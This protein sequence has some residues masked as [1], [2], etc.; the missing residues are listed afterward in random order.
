MSGADV[1]I[2]YVNAVT[3]FSATTNVLVAV[4][5]GGMA[6]RDFNVSSGPAMRITSLSK[7]ATIQNLISVHRFAVSLPRRNETMF[8]AVNGA[9]L[10]E[11]SVLSITGDGIIMGPTTFLPNRVGGGTI[12]SLVASVMVTDA[13]TPGLRS[14]VVRH[15]NDVAYA[16]GYVEIPAAVTDYNFDGLDDYFQRR[17]WSPWTQAAAGPVADPDEDHFSNAFEARMET[18][19]INAQSFRLPISGVTRDGDTTRVTVQTDVGKRYQLFERMAF[20]GGTWAA[21]GRALTATGMELTF[22]DV[23][24]LEASFYRVALLP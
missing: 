20:G 3:S 16:N 19:P 8:V 2:D 14:F 4:G 12:H 23:S 11:G 6:S 13:A 24:A 17:Y 1:A 21:V 7:P 5:A 22:S 10:K 15:G 9:T 18:N